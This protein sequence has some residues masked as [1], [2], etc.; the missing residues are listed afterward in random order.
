LASV[1]DGASGPQQ[2]LFDG[3]PADVTV[4]PAVAEALLA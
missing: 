4:V 1:G 3:T 2:D